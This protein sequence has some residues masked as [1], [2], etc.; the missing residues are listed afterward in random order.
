MVWGISPETPGTGLGAL[1]Y[2]MRH[3]G[4]VGRPVGG[5]GALT[6][7][8]AAAVVRAGGEV[9]TGA[10]VTGIRCDGDARASASRSPTAREID[11][12][13]VV[14]ACDPRRTFVEWLSSPPAG[15]AGDDRPLARRDGAAGYESKIDA[16]LTAEPRLRDSEHRLSSTLTIAPTIAEMD[17]AAAML[18][19]GGDPRAAG[20]ARQRAV[21]RRPDDGARRA[22]T[23]SASRCC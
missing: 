17:R 20:P 7:A 19:T 9:R 4:H 21:D 22:A 15:A 1:S 2:A 23:C 3:V 13:I 18:P 12:P 6:E 14:S 11:A 8:L 5:S 16:V 10:T